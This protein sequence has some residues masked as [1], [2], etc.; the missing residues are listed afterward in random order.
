MKPFIYRFFVFLFF[1]ELLTRS[2]LESFHKFRVFQLQLQRAN[3][4]DVRTTDKKVEFLKLNR[5]LLFLSSFMITI[6]LYF[7]GFP[8]HLT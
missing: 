1:C 8:A 4:D 6:R 2:S 3:A 7:D 5:L